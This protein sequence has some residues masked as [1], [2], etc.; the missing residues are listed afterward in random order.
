MI[1]GGDFFQIDLKTNS[2]HDNIEKFFI[3]KI[4]VK[5]FLSRER[6]KE[7]ELPFRAY[8]MAIRQ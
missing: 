7:R 6:R 8:A 3:K 4:M 5:T 2:I 1:C